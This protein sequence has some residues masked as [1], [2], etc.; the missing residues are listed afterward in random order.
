VQHVLSSPTD[1]V[2]SMATSG[3]Y[4]FGGTDNCTI[5]VL[6]CFVSASFVWSDC[7]CVGV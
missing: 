4:L 7:C 2:L 1:K 5:Q 3:D 6:F